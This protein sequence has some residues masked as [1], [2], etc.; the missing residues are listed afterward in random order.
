MNKTVKIEIPEDLYNALLVTAENM[1][2]Q[3][4]RA[5]ASPYFFQIQETKSRLVPDGFGSPVWVDE[6]GDEYNSDEE[7]KQY[8]RDYSSLT[9]EKI[10]D[11]T[12]SELEYQLEKRGLRKYEKESFNTLSNVFFTEVAA[13]NHIRVNGHNLDSPRDYISFGFR[14]PELENVVKL[15]LL[16]R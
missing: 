15:L 10:D 7:V 16:I 12:D 2:K 4:N 11:L 3:D 14:N 8:L 13:R 9:E 5:T 1:R 6:D